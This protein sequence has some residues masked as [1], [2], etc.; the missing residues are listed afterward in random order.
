MV[1]H[2]SEVEGASE[3]NK[4]SAP[5]PAYFEAA[6]SAEALKCIRC[7]KISDKGCP[8]CET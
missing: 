6:E 4:E 5:V 7:S 1:L 8:G 3:P 2:S